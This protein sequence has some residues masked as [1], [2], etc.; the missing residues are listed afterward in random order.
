MAPRSPG[1]CTPGGHDVHTAN[2]LAV[3]ELLFRTRER[4]NGKVKLVFQPAEENGGGGREMIKA[5]LMEKSRTP[6]LPF[7]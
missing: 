7:M 6:A 2:L 3:G 4:W 5:G 1:S